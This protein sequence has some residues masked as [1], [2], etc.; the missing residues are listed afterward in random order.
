MC[1]R[2]TRL[3]L[4]A[5]ENVKRFAN[6][7]EEFHTHTHTHTVEPAYNDIGFYDTPHMPSDIFGTN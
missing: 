3:E 4:T 2:V 1:E 6:I 5:L 7:A